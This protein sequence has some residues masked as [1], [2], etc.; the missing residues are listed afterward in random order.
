MAE[1]ARANL[2]AKLAHPT[3]GA[4]RSVG[5]HPAWMRLIRYCAEL[6]HGEIEKLKIQ[7]GV[8][9]IADVVREKVKFT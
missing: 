5:V 6:G 1:M 8:P 9:V 2:E 7:D 4:A 3:S